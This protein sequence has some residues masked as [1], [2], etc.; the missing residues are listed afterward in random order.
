MG[1]ASMFSSLELLKENIGPC[2]DGLIETV[3]SLKYENDEYQR[4]YA[5]T[6]DEL[7]DYADKFRLKK[8][9][10]DTVLNLINYIMGLYCYDK[11]DSLEEAG[12]DVQS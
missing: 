9:N 8:A 11:L 4:V 10:A 12:I 6:M 1:C 7:R 3:E 5:E 2:I